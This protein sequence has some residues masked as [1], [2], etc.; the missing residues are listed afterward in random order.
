M[1]PEETR[2]VVQTRDQYETLHAAIDDVVAECNK[3]P[4]D[5]VKNLKRQY[6]ESVRDA[7]KNYIETQNRVLAEPAARIKKLNDTAEKAQE[8]ID[9]ALND[10]K[11]IKKALN[12]I[13]KAVKGVSTVVAMLT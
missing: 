13:T 10:L 9:D 3:A 11:N 1:S 6:G 2:A 7:F 5:Q 8:S 12:N 4:A